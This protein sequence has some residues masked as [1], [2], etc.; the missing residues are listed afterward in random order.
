MRKIVG[1]RQESCVGCN[2]CTRACP[3]DTANITYQDELGSI[4]VKVDSEKC[5]ACGSCITVCKHDARVFVD[6]TERFFDDLASGVP[7]SLIAAPSIRTNFP[8]WKRLLTFLR[9]KGVRKIYDVSLGAD[10]CIWAHLAYINSYKPRSV[11][12]QPCAAI[13]SFC[14]IHNHK[15]LQHLSPVHSPMACTA[16]YMNNYNGI[17]DRIAALSPCIA[18]ANEFDDIGIIHYNVTYARLIDYLK[19]TNTVVPDEETN[20]DHHDCSLGSLFPS[21]GGLMENI[22]FF[23]G[24]T[25]R[26]DRAEGSEVYH[27]LTTYAAL[28]NE[29]LPQIFDVLSCRDGC[30]SGSGCIQNHNLFEIQSNMDKTRQ[31][32]LSRRDRAYFDDLYRQYNQTFKLSDFMREYKPV[33]IPYVEVTEAEINRAFSK[34]SKDTYAKQNFNC[35]ACGSD[36]CRDMARKIALGINLPL[37]CIVKSR[38]DTVL[39]Q[40]KNSELYKRTIRYISMVHEIGESLLSISGEGYIT[41]VVNS[42][43]A[44]CHTLDSNSAHV[45]KTMK[46][47]QD[48]LFYKRYYLWEDPLQP[49]VSI[50]ADIMYADLFPEHY[51]S[52]LQNGNAVNI[53]RNLM[54]ERAADVLNNKNLHSLLLVPINVNGE[55]WGLISLSNSQ[56]QSRF[57]TEEEISVITATGILIISTIIEKELNESLTLAREQALSSTRA[58]SEFLSRMSHEI[59]TPMNAIIGMTKIADTSSDIDK[60]KYCLSNIASS[61]SH[62]LGLINDILDMSKIEAGK[63]ELFDAPFRLE[64]I[65]DKI[66]ILLND[67]TKQNDQTLSIVL[68]QN[69]K[70]NYIGDELRLSQVLVNLLGNAVKFTPKCGIITLSI[71]EIERD[72]RSC[73]LQFNVSDTGIGMSQEQINRLFNPFE[74]ADSSISTKYGGT[75]LGLTISKNIIEKMDGRIW[76]ESEPGEGSTFSFQIRLQYDSDSYLQDTDEQFG[77]SSSKPSTTLQQQSIDFSS[78]HLLLVDD[79]EINRIIFIALLEDTGL[80]IDCATNGLEALQIFQA[81]PEQYDIIIMDLQMPVMNGHEATR[82]IRALDHPRAKTIPIIA[83]T[84]NAF[85]EDVE[86]CLES[87]MNDHLAK[88]IDEKMLKEKITLYYNKSS[89]K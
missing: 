19:V 67:K 45:W 47:K 71:S 20:F 33:Q 70:M 6:D 66:R 35:G 14:E 26:I 24:K 16:V 2:R 82:A 37:N 77:G 1:S 42:L 60:L 18:K 83:M 85:R 80:S 86:K 29:L 56:S 48:R 68:D 65:V 50:Q 11:I 52:E 21:P 30:N 87:G 41:A 79:I 15:L 12:T 51:I 4:K 5:I 78:I 76:V 75:G 28:D 73:V 9:N 27:H 53:T 32:T 55:L 36:T 59:R 57:Y 89:N 81:N 49:D 39:E 10:I 64:K 54:S 40:H 46:D 58:K 17:T 31:E 62:L 72:T 84:A 13:V 44:L 23:V 7:I 25:M 22:E 43:K 61:S 88:P 8:D 74:Q 3:I 34:M 69:I 63:Y 38:D